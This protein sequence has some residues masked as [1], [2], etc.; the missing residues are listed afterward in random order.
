MPLGIIF[1]RAF[2]DIRQNLVT[3]IMTTIVVA[4]TCLVFIFFSIFSLNLQR[5]ADR[6]GR[7]LAIVVY[8]KKDIPQNKIPSLYQKI[9][10]MK[11]V[12]KVKFISSEEA[13]KRLEN[14]FKDEKEVLEGVD[15]LFLP[16]SFEIQINR[17]VYNPSRVRAMA[18]ELAQWP[19]VQ[20]VQ[21]GKEWVDRLE[22]F[23]EAVR[24]AVIASA[25]LLLVTAAFVV[26]NTIK[27]TVY[28]RQDE[29]E[30]MRLVGATNGF[31]QGPFLLASFI[32]GVT[33]SL[34]A[35]IVGLFCYKYVYG[36]IGQTELI[37]SLDLQ[38]LPPSYMAVIVLVSG[39]FCMI[40]TAMALR[41]F[42]KL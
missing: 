19:E 37:K 38:Y 9:T 30:I 42:L 7:E 16:P 33:G 32:Q 29:I 40:G 22:S 12:E 34:V 1:K 21:Y 41:R 39:F 4:L 8:L 25:V 6:F 36:I 17:A 31:I 2:R 28:A 26:S 27:L 5:I 15:P 35:L 20:K 11:E 13:F 23:S 18:K 14:Y 3:H 10:S 24:A